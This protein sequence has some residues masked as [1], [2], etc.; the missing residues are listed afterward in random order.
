M[1][2]QAIFHGDMCVGENTS[3][4]ANVRIVRHRQ[5]M[6]A[7]QRD[8]REA[9]DATP[10]LSAGRSFLVGKVIMIIGWRNQSRIRLIS[11]PNDKFG[12]E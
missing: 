3:R 6:S 7:L 10:R 9:C 4:P 2:F 8:A 12:S 11:L 5:T 1:D